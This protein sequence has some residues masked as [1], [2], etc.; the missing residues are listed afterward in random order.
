MD[1][2]IAARGLALA[3]GI[4]A[5]ATFVPAFACTCPPLESAAAQADGADLVALARMEGDA[6]IGQSPYGGPER[7]E[8]DFTLL[9]VLKGD[10]LA[11]D[12]IL[13]TSGAP[14]N[15][16]CG[17]RWREGVEALVL[18]NARETGGYSAWMCSM[19]QFSEAEFREA[20]GA[21]P[22]GGDQPLAPLTGT[23][24]IL[25]PQPGERISGPVPIK[26]T[27]PADWFFE[28]A[29]HGKLVEAG[30]VVGEIPIRPISSQNWTEPG[31][32]TVDL[33]VSLNVETDTDLTLIIEQSLVDETL[34]PRSVSVAFTAAAPVGDPEAE[35][36][37][38]ME[39]LVT[40]TWPEVILS[41]DGEAYAAFLPE[42]YLLVDETGQVID[43]AA[44]IT[45]ITEDEFAVPD[46]LEVKVL[47]SRLVSAASGLVVGEVTSAT[48]ITDG[49]VCEAVFTVTHVLKRFGGDWS[50]EAS[51]FSGGAQ[52]C[53]GE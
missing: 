18:L 3:I 14:G 41:G 22:K 31:D 4:A 48:T 8:T 29:A 24:E 2:L 25:S 35:A 23:A 50:L 46:T 43:R 10:A 12:E 38:E 40:E 39:R 9:E 52:T 44:M 53:T 32:K 28:N 42:D 17:I 7:I 16:A 13:V 11:G 1:I 21:P 49:V 45:L 19:P 26:A 20:L 34:A 51:H 37:A 47:D 36:R 30:E 15:P 5:G 6:E 33:E 27:L